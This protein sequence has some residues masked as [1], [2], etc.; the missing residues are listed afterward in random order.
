MM[1]RRHT[2]NKKTWK[3]QNIFFVASKELHR[4]H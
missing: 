2:N 4:I 1:G 3:T